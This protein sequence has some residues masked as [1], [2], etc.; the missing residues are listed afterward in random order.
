MRPVSPKPTAGLNR[1]TALKLGGAG[2]AAAALARPH[3][4]SAADVTLAVWTG[5]PEL[6]A[7]YQAVGAAYSKANPGVKFSF[8]SASLREAEQKLTA[9]VPTGTGPDIYDVGTNISIAFIEGEHNPVGDG[10]GRRV[11]E[12]TAGGPQRG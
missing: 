9:A 10:R 2:F 8:L 6:V 12:R 7:Y 11:Q 5:Y 3:V 4:A 1:R